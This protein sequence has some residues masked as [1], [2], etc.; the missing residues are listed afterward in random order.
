M[1]EETKEI[2]M[3]ATTD[4]SVDY[5]LRKAIESV[6]FDNS[7][8]QKELAAFVK[9]W[10]KELFT[11]YGKRTVLRASS[12]Y[13]TSHDNAEDILEITVPHDT[14]LQKAKEWI[15]FCMVYAHIHCFHMKE[16]CD[17]IMH[18]IALREVTNLILDLAE[19]KRTI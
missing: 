16:A 9:K 8:I 15:L 7:S 19:K 6:L 10:E 14:S 1:D 12:G 11:G 2:L 4:T 5:D 18:N 13:F 3:K 17:G